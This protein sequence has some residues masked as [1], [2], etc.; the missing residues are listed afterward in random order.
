MP[1]NLILLS[2][3]D[4]FLN[5]LVVGHKMLLSKCFDRHKSWVPIMTNFQLEFVKSSSSDCH[6]I[7]MLLGSLSNCLQVQFWLWS[8]RMLLVSNNNAHSS[9]N[10]YELWFL[11]LTVVLYIRMLLVLN[12][13]FVILSDILVSYSDCFSFEMLQVLT[14]TMIVPPK[15]YKVWF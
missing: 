15:A 3:W 5:V 6:S 13:T 11:V 8:N 14:L 12:M 10:A 2:V 9:V 1:W 4:S 7:S